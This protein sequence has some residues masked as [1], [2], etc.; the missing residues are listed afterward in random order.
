MW[1][2]HA[3]EYYSALKRKE[4]LQHAMTPMTPEDVLPNEISWSQRDKYHR[5]LLYE[6]LRVTKFT[7]TEVEWRLPGA[8]GSGGR[9]QGALVFHG[10][11]T[12]VGKDE[13]APEEDS[14]DGGAT[15]RVYF[16]PPN[17]TL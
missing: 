11:P 10:R 16:V 5:F 2:I 9:G 4:T 17:R 1:Y 3:M 8:G 15:I 6:I 12:A 7:N 14:G 13:G